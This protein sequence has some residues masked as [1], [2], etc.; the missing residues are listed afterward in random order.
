MMD[1]GGFPLIT[2][3]FLFMTSFTE[4]VLNPSYPSSP[5]K[6]RIIGYHQDEE[7]HWVAELECGQNQHVRHVPPWINRLWVTT[8]EGRSSQLGQMLDCEEC[9]RPT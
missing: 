5:M 2:I 3:E 6:K 1:Y 7:Q 4:K 8:A 9:D